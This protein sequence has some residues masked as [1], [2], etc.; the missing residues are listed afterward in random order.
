MQFDEDFRRVLRHGAAPAGLAVDLLVA[1]FTG[2]GLRET[3]TF[4]L[5]RS[6]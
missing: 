2:V 3:V 6:E 4:P 5:M 1:R